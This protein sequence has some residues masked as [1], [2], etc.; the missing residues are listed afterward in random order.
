MNSHRILRFF[1]EITD[2]TSELHPVYTMLGENQAMTPV[3]D[4]TCPRPREPELLKVKNRR[5]A[6]RYNLSVPLRYRAP[7]TN[8]PSGWKSGRTLDMSASG[9]SIEIPETLDAG[10]TLELVID[11][12]GLY[13]GRPAVRLFLTCLVVRIDAQSTALRIVSHQFREA[14]YAGTRSGRTEGT[15]AVAS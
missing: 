9:L 13:H 3:C 4:R 6:T 15:L 10:A 11:W 14:S 12:T 2:P 1:R 5:G 8:L 7:E